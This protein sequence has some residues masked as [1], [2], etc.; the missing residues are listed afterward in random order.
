MRIIILGCIASLLLLMAW[1]L[2]AVLLVKS[3]EWTL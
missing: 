3:W 1:A 2:A